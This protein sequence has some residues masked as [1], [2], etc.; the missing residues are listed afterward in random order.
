M[1]IFNFSIQNNER[2]FRE[3]DAILILFEDVNDVKT[4]DFHLLEII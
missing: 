4:Y 1:E 3:L 2:V